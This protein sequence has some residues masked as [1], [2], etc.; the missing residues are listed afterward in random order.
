MNCL[1][2][3]G[4]SAGCG[5]VA[6]TG[7]HAGKA[8]GGRAGVHSPDTGA[9]GG[10]AYIRLD[11]AFHQSRSLHRALQSVQAAGDHHQQPALPGAQVPVAAHA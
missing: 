2:N 7:P 8:D 4:L 5:A 10:G 3:T 1:W 11:A 9:C 6:A